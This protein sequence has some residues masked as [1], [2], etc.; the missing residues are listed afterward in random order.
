MPLPHFKKTRKNQLAFHLCSFLGLLTL[1]ILLPL[2]SHAKTY[3]VGSKTFTEG[4]ILSEVVAQHL[5]DNG[6]NVDRKFGLQ[7]RLAFASL[8]NGSIDFYIEYSGTLAKVE[9]KAQ[10]NMSFEEVASA[11]AEKDILLFAPLGFSN[12]YALAVRREFAEENN[13]KTIEDLR[14]KKIRISFSN[15][16]SRRD[17]A[18][19]AIRKTYGLNLEFETI[20]HGLTYKALTAKA[21]DMTDVYST[22]AKIKKYDLVLLED[23]KGVFPSYEAAILAP[24]DLDPKVKTLLEELSGK[25]DDELMTEI[26]GWVEFE[27]LS[28]CGAAKRFLTQNGMGDPDRRCGSKFDLVMIGKQT[29]E[30]LY[31]TGVALIAAILLSIPLGILLYRLKIPSLTQPIIFTSGILQTIPSLAL[32]FFMVPI[33]QQTGPLPAIVGLFLYSILPILRNT[34]TALENVDRRLI[35][36]GE[37]LGLKSSEVLKLIELPLAAPVIL[38][39][40]RTAAV[41]SVGTATF[42]AFIGAGG[43]GESIVQGLSLN[44][45]TLMLQGVI[46]ASLL[47]ISIEVLFELSERFWFAGRQAKQA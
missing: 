24:L 44:D 35:E 27:G 37:G 26:N 20:E 17:D 40:V 38:A 11:M 32:L 39:G 9:L 10:K 29:A 33:F 18:Y 34:L 13:L 28:F 1:W 4:F 31:L 3:V 6:Y 2:S 42:A 5:E 41:I 43:L 7:D 12:T 46:P 23:T 21:T 15:G 19:P 47:A 22:D 8:E 16:F 25:I 45:N 36:V 14:E 30:T